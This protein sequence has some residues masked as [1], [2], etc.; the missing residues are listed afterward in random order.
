MRA[1]RPSPI[2]TTSPG[3]TAAVVVNPNNP[4]GRALTPAQVLAMAPRGGLLVVDEAFA[5][6]MPEGLSLV[7]HLPG[8]GIVVLRS[9]GK[10]YGLAGL[11]LGF[12]VASPD[13]APRIRSALGPWAVSGPA[14]EIGTRALDD[15]VWLQDA[16][17]RLLA[18][19]ARLDAGLSAAGAR[20]VGGTPL[21]R[22]A[23]VDDGPG[24]FRHLAR[25]GILVRP[26]A[27]RPHWL[28][29]GIPTQAWQWDRL[30]IALERRQ[31][32]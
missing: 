16:R 2:R 4:D 18:G 25:H 15:R 10:A 7:P 3:S 17:T 30:A 5:D 1:S 21:F 28:R 23:E 14:I 12:A 24:W 31:P 6:L 29:L 20:I 32:R 13:L 26:F 27:E 8:R 11:R 9:F 22:L 19:A